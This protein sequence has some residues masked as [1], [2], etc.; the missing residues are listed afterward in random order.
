MLMSPNGLVIWNINII[1]IVKLCDIIQEV[2][3]YAN[4]VIFI[5]LF[6]FV[7]KS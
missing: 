1:I 4:K 5:I 7:S 3:W 6:V 2:L